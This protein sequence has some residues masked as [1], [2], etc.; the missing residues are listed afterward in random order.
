VLAQIYIGKSALAKKPEQAIIPQPL[1][2]LFHHA[3][4]FLL[5]QLIVSPKFANS[6]A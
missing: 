2:Y 6:F 1:L 3:L 5:D 4:Y